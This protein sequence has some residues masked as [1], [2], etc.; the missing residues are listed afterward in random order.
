MRSDNLSNNPTSLAALD[1]REQLDSELA[2]LGLGLF[3][4]YQCGPT[5]DEAETITNHP[6]VLQPPKV[7]EGYQREQLLSLSKRRIKPF[8]WS[9]ENLLVNADEESHVPPVAEGASFIVH[10]NQGFY[11]ILNLCSLGESHRFRE[12]VQ[13]H[14]SDIQM[15][16]VS[17]YDESLE[18]SAP[19]PELPTSILTP[20][21]TEVL[22]WT[23]IGKTYN[24][25]SLL[26]NMSPRTVKFHMKNIFN[27]LEVNNG[28][29]AIRK[30]LQ[31]GYIKEPE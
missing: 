17:V 9:D 5:L 25:I 30:A 14:K 2:N 15:L 20:R 8:F 6:E 22:S 19:I 26:A 21:E 4:V 27:K 13:A 1:R 3:E 28:K 11:S 31:L 23:S 24:E 18:S 12:T 7:D 16:L 10:G 29:S